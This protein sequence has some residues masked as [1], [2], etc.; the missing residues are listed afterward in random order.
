MGN[1]NDKF[2]IM[3]KNKQHTKYVSLEYLFIYL[4]IR[5]AICLKTIKWKFSKEITKTRKIG[6]IGTKK[7]KR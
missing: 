7:I 2:L 4:F 5:I 3:K 6:S 1:F